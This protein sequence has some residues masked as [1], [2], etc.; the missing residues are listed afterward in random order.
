MTVVIHDT[1]EFPSVYD[2]F[3]DSAARHG[4]HPFLIL[5][6]RCARE[7][8]FPASLSYAEALAEVNRLAGLYAARGLTDGCT[9]ALALDSRPSHL[10]H[11]L[12]L[13]KLGA[14]SVPLNAE[15]TPNEQAYVLTHARCAAVIALPELVPLMTRAVAQTGRDIPIA[16]GSPA[17]LPHDP[18]IPWRFGP[19]PDPALRPAAILYTS[20][21]TGKPKG[22]VLSNRYAQAS[23][24][25]YAA[26][27]PALTLRTGADRV[28]NPLPLFHMNALM[29]TAGGV[30]ERGAALVLQGR[31][32]LSHWWADLAETGATRFHY[33]GLMIPALLARPPTH[34]DRDHGVLTGFGAGVDPGAH[35][36]FEERF[37]IPLHE[38]WGMTETGRGLSVVEEP[39]HVDSRA[40]GRPGPGFE[41]RIAR[42]DGTE[43]A[44]GEAGELQARTT[45]TDPRWGFF[46]GYLHDPQ[47]TEAAWD[48]GWFHTGDICT[49]APDGMVFFVDRRKN[50]VRRSGENISSAEV[51]AVLSALPEVAQVAVLAVPDAMR[52]EEV[53]ACIVPVDPAADESTARDICTRS[54]ERLAHFKAPGWLR[55]V[56]ELPVTSTQKVQKHLIF[57]DGFDPGNP[58]PRTHDCRALKRRPPL[59]ETTGQTS[60]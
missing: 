31:F 26:P 41:V 45:G 38:V 2:F 54:Q 5:P 43:A 47:A 20:G 12:A 57:P 35:V 21:T 60:R 23:G 18:Q 25:Y 13:N 39:R 16:S 3:A 11:Y 24:R 50:I 55:F 44:T 1:R 15:L 56:D 29:M 48:G 17:A 32:S 33:L 51:E 14:C 37:G 46:S 27:S 22:C 7:W 49:R 6:G 28:M 4:T 52:D 36:A 10:L 40:C 9:V 30:I 34:H 58:G 42:E 8:A 19:V 53:M 59:P